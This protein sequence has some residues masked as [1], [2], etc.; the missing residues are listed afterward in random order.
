MCL[1]FIRLNCSVNNSDIFLYTDLN[2]FDL[3]NE[4]LAFRSSVE[5]R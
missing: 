5:I 4:G 2:Y 3:V 1:L